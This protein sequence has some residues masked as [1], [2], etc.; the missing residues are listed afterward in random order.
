MISHATIEQP[1]RPAGVEAFVAEAPDRAFELRRY[2][3][4]EA[5][6]E[7]REAW[8]GLVEQCGGNLCS[9]FDWCRVWWG[10]FGSRRRLEIYLAWAD[11]QLVGV[12]PLFR[13]TLRW[14]PLSLRVVRIVGCDHCTTTCV[15]AIARDW[16]SRAVAALIS[17]LGETGRWDLIH[18]AELPGCFSDAES[19]A[20]VFALLLGTES[21]SWSKDDYP[22]MAFDVPEDFERYLATLS[23]KERRNVRHDE[24]RLRQAGR[25]TRD[26]PVDVDSLDRGFADLVAMHQDQWRRAGQ[27]GHFGDW[28]GVAAFHREIAET[29]LARRRLL[30]ISV[31]VDGKLQAVEYGGCLGCRATW[32]IGGRRSDVTSRVGFCALLRACMRR[33][34]SEIDALQGFYDYKRR[35]GARRLGIQS[36]GVTAP[37]PASRLRARAFHAATWLADLVYYRIWYWRLA[38]RLRGRGL[39]LGEGS[40]WRRYIRCRFLVAARRG[41]RSEAES[42]HS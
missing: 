39:Q 19:L 41:R 26:E 40:L 16:M 18:L 28:P 13:E 8:D 17:A 2:D 6:E 36:I 10:H 38:P 34:V 31:H 32:L 33:G 21:V 4:F 11:E 23:L 37:R 9:S 35:L 24:R 29:L 15:I 25:V 20:E 5:L 12:I 1:T 3:G 30:L 42:E 7:F 27:L 22:Q 14:G